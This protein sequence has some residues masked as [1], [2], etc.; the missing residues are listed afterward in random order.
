M[1]LLFD[2][3]ISA[4]LCALLADL[5]PGS[6]QV[7]SLGLER[8]ADREVW[9][10]ARVNGFTIVTQDADFANLAA[11]YGPPPRVVWRRCGKRPTAQ[12]EALIRNQ[13]EP[14]LGMEHDPEKAI[15]EILW[16][17]GGHE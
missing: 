3:N 15:L 7:R 11:Y 4:K 6:A 12:V 10:Y 16:E 2:Q 14:I 13:A 17:G 8:S 1:R 9:D 5:F